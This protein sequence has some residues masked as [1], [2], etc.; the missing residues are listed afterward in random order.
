M[1]VGTP[2]QSGQKRD[3]NAALVKNYNPLCF[4]LQ[5]HAVLQGYQL[6]TQALGVLELK[7]ARDAFL[8]SLCSFALSPKMGE[9]AE[10]EVPMSPLATTSGSGA[11]SVVIHQRAVANTKLT[12]TSQRLYTQLLK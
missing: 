9:D 11:C 8:S 6:F 12:A 10:G 4:C 7:E 2:F 3:I 1:S 5:S